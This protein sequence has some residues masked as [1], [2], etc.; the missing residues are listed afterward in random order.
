[1]YLTTCGCL[2][3]RDCGPNVIKDGKCRLCRANKVSANPIGSSLPPKHL[4]L[5][6][7]LS[8]QPSLKSITRREQFKTKHIRRG[9]EVQSRL[10]K[11]WKEEIN[12]K[13]EERK[14]QRNDV[15]NLEKQVEEK[16][17]KLKLLE[18]EVRQLEEEAKAAP[19]VGAVA[20]G[21][22][23][24]KRKG[25]KSYTNPKG[26]GSPRLPTKSPFLTF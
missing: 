19:K 15:R 4:D 11:G 23:R 21:G 13:E 25:G 10:E 1:M 16:M 2:V 17:E 20:T 22:A 6:R 18:E 14:K 9:L 7:P 5:F 26:S 24:K 12:K 8:D 3:C